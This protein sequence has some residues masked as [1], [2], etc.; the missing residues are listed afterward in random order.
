MNDQEIAVW[1]AT[2][3]AVVAAGFY[4]LWR[5]LRQLEDRGLIYGNHNKPKPG[6]VRNAALEM[7]R[8][9]QPAVEHRLE[10]DDAQAER[11]END[12]D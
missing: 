4:L 2:R 10:A 6:G 3:A 11:A 7:E 12:G 8:I 5:L 1:L 9:I